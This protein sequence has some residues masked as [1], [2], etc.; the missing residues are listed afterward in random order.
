MT[1]ESYRSFRE[2]GRGASLATSGT[3]ALP[4]KAPQEFR[5]SGK[6]ELPIERGP[7]PMK[8][9]GSSR[10]ADHFELPP[11]VSFAKERLPGGWA[12]V[13][14]HRTLGLLGRILLQ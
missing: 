9:K 4:A 12:Y 1:G 10:D 6:N 3:A 7:I 13:F 11:E 5:R 14:R 8:C 2:P